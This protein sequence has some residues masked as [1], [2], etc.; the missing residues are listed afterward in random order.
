MGFE[1]DIERGKSGK[2]SV[3]AP[4][5]TLQKAIDLG[6]YKPEYLAIFPEWHGLSAHVQLQFIRQG[7]D[8][9]RAQLLSQWAEMD[10]AIDAS[11][12]PELQVAK[13]QVFTQ[14]QILEKDREDLLTEYSSRI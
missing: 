6:E 5:M 8:N 2:R 4:N 10:R 14:L 9:R 3:K 11:K 13:E 1:D 7:I 12:K